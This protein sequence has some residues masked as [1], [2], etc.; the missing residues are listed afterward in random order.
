MKTINKIDKYFAN[1]IGIDNNTKLVEEEI[2]A[3]DLIV[4]NR[5]DLIAKLKYIESID[6]NINTSFY[7]DLYKETLS[8]FSDGTFMEPGNK[9]K[10]SF[11]SYIKSFNKMIKDIKI[12]GFKLYIFSLLPN[13]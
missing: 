10:N 1:V 7:K 13:I 6:K 9:N 12:N 2:N 5:I 11:D 3:K 8:C 4:S